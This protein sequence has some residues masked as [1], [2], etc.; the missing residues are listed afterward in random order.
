MI[1]PKFLKKNSLIGITSP[2]SG[3][4]RKLE[5]HIASEEIIIN[6][7]FRILETASV[8]V[9]NIRSNTAKN[10]AKELNSLFLD[11]EVEMC[12]ISTGGDF[13]YEILPYIDFDAIEENP[14]WI[15]GYS[16]PTNLMYVVTTMLDIATLY[17]N[18]ASS[19]NFDPFK[20]NKYLF[21][22][23]KGKIN[24]Q[25]SYKEFISAQDYHNDIFKKQDVKY[26][27]NKKEFTVTGRLL[28]G[29]FEVI[30]KLLGTKYDYTLNFIDKYKDDGTIFFFDVYAL[31]S[32]NFYLTLLQM[33][34]AGYFSNL[35]CMIVG[36]I[37]Y[38]SIY[39]KD[40]DYFKA[41]KKVLGNIPII[42]DA[43]IGHSKPS[44]TYINGAI[45]TI[46]YKDNKGS[47]A[48]KLK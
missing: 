24:K 20:S 9:N 18:N 41:A 7:G 16:D 39:S 11:D 35:K 34:Y 4:G 38:P 13:M 46:S 8:R 33:K 36:R 21:D 19:L 23:L 5:D 14:K 30:E 32:Y 28:G 15:S 43:D 48:F 31:D 45:A 17:G 37:G 42:M 3:V 1:Y 40:L 47:I 10:R 26:L 27:S 25:H 29:C 44:Q 2:S 12:F 22:I 6:E